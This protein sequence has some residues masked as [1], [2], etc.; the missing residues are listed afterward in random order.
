MSE[1]KYFCPNCGAPVA[2]TDKFCQTC[3]A[4]LIDQTDARPQKPYT[5]PPVQ[6]QPQHPYGQPTPTQYSG[7]YAPPTQ[8]ITPGQPPGPYAGR[9]MPVQRAGPEYYA[10]VKAGL[11]SRVLAY[12]LDSLIFGFIGSFCFIIP[13][14]KDVIPERGKSFGKA[15]LNLKVVDY[16]TGLPITAGQA[17]MR[18]FGYLLTLGFDIFVPFCTSD[19]RRVGD[20]LAGSIVIE[21]V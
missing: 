10:Q 16:D 9:I 5:Q 6:P 3:G 1:G 15:M 18:N 20:Y 8:P 4:K 19:G 13:W 11:G 2:A 14:F 17:C 7:P 12:I 21:D